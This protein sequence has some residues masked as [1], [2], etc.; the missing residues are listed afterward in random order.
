MTRVNQ[1]VANPY[2]QD[3]KPTRWQKTAAQILQTPQG[4]DAWLANQLKQN[5]TAAKRFLLERLHWISQKLMAF[6]VSSSA[7]VDLPGLQ[8]WLGTIPV[9]RATITILASWLYLFLFPTREILALKRQRPD[10]LTK[11]VNDVAI[12]DLT[13]F[14]LMLYILDPL[15][16][17]FNRNVTSKMAQLPLVSKMETLSYTQLKQ[18]YRIRSANQ[19]AALAQH[20]DTRLGLKKALVELSDRGLSRHGFTGLQQGIQ[21]FQTIGLQLLLHPKNNTLAQQTYQAMTQLNTLVQQAKQVASQTKNPGLLKAANHIM[22]KYNYNHFLSYYATRF[23]VPAD[24]ASL[25]AVVG[26]AG[27]LPMALNNFF[28]LQAV[29]RYQQT[30][31]MPLQ[32]AGPL[33]GLI[34]SNQTRQG[35]TIF[36]AFDHPANSKPRQPA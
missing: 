12:R 14:A 28:S 9:T 13:S 26:L 7:M 24:L 23:R 27:W 31:V 6:D 36:A 3:V 34:A 11:E 35:K 16:R 22:A 8:K 29:K 19:L 4:G 30:H 2:W 10:D 1:W 32:P 33:S 15:V 25:V 5:P 21:H 17:W 18:R 20:P